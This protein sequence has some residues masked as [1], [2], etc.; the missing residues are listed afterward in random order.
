MILLDTET[1]TLLAGSHPEVTERLATAKDEVGITVVTRIE[2][3]GGRFAFLM[4]AAHGEELLRA[5]QWLQRTEV[6]LAR[7]PAIPFDAAAAAVFDR[8]LGTKGL[9]KAGRGDLLIASIALASRATQVTRNR[10][11]FQKVPG[12]WIENWVD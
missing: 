6:D 12:L 9:K 3:L 11:D 4:R 2:A 1:F 8:L 5:Q 7:L 10:K